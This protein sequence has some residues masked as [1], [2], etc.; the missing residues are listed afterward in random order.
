M[1]A[2]FTPIRLRELTLSNR[3]VISPMC[4]YSADY[5]VATDWHKIHLGSLALSGAGMMCIEATGV[6]PEGRISPQCLG[7]WDDRTE[8]ALAQTLAAVRK[9]SAIPIAIQLGHAGR[10]ASVHVPW[11]GGTIPPDAPGGWVTKAPSAIPFYP[12]GPAPRALDQTGL[13]QVRDAFVASARRADRAGLDAIEL[14]GAHGYLLH[15]FLSP[16]SNRRDDAYGGSLENRMRFPLE[17]FDAVRAVFPSHKPVGM[18]VSS[19]DWVESGWD[20]EQTIEFA[21]ALEARGVDWIDA[22]SGG[23]DPNQKI[24]IGPGYQVPFAAALKR[25][26]K[27]PIFA[28]GLITEPAQAEAIIAEGKAD[29][30]ALARAMLFDP[31]W[32][33]AAARALGA[34]VIAPPQYWRSAPHGT[35]GLFA[36]AH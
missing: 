24:P 4:Q 30:V 10:K 11:E 7:L 14:H 13:A 33:W 23:N 16:I 2:L 21:K 36:N 9:Y 19:S 17:V 18:R 8:A 34:N 25:A 12:D 15:E 28:V 3:I 6:E 27:T 35:K 1:S 32:P 26:V 5:G 31:H 20:I 29:C 22:S